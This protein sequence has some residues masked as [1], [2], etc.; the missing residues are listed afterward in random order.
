M[1]DLHVDFNKVCL[2]TDHVSVQMI[3]K[4]IDGEEITLH[5]SKSARV[6]LLSEVQ[7]HLYNTRQEYKKHIR[8]VKEE[9]EKRELD[10]RRELNE[11]AAKKLRDEINNVLDKKKYEDEK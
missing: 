2:D 8:K 6:K 1:K 5:F 4:E 7:N 11:R 9:E 3:V 10:V